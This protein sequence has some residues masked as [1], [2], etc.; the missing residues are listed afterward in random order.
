MVDLMVKMA[1]MMESLM[2]SELGEMQKIAA[3]C[4]AM[5]QQIVTTM[6]Y[7]GDMAEQI[8]IMAGRIVTTADLMEAL[9]ND[10]SSPP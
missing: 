5:A 9:L 4:G 10:C 2:T 6:G 1:A 7:I 8:N 3:A